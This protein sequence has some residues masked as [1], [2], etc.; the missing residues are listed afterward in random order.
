VV[1]NLLTDEEWTVFAP[2]L[3]EAIP[4]SGVW[5][6]LLQALASTPTRIT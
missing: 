3:T 6:V 4:A 1:R 2:F 5:D